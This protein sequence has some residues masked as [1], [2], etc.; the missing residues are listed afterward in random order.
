MKLMVLP[1]QLLS[2]RKSTKGG[3]VPVPDMDAAMMLG[4]YFKELHDIPSSNAKK[5][6][7]FLG[8]NIG[9]YRHQKA[10]DLLRLIKEDLGQGDS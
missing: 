7:L 4:D 10:V 5:V 3:D 8:A 2:A 6:V 9:N 1:T